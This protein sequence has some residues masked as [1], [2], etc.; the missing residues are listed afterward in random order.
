MNGSVT[1]KV[2]GLMPSGSGLLASS[3]RRFGPKMIRAMISTTRISG[4]PMLPGIPHRWYR[5]GG[6][7]TAIPL[8]L[9]VQ[10]EAAG[11][12]LRLPLILTARLSGAIWALDRGVHA[13]ERDLPDRHRVIDRHGQVGD[14]RELE[15]QVALE[16][17]IH[18]SRRRMDEEPE[19][20]KRALSL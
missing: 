7:A 11:R 14:V 5:R 1:P 10:V 3:G 9:K 6:P 16:A 4:N 12:R 8:T 20:A 15:R 17:G 2:I 19:P 18:E 13:H